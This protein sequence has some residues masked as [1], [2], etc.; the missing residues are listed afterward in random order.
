[1]QKNLFT[2]TFL[3]NH[4]IDGNVITHSI[5]SAIENIPT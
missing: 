1:M 5:I 2:H 4:F 3:I